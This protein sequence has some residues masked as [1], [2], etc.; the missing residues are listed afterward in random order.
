MLETGDFVLGEMALAELELK[1]T[2]L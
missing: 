1:A 2:Q